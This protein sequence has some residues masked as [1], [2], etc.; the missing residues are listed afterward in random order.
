M[1]RLHLLLVTEQVL[2]VKA[3]TLE[4]KNAVTNYF[5]TLSLKCQAKHPRINVLYFTFFVSVTFLVPVKLDMQISWWA[6]FCEP[7]SALWEA[8]SAH[9]NI[10][11]LCQM[12]TAW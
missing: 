12:A 7:P 2:S 3:S 8:R 9:L 4:T 5:Y 6:A 11:V 10:E 1:G